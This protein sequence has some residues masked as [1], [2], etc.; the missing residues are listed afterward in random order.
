MVRIMAS[1]CFLDLGGLRVIYNAYF[2]L[3]AHTKQLVLVTFK[4]KTAGI[5]VG[6]WMDGRMDGRK[7]N[8]RWTDRCGS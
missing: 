6:F 1:P 2:S 4:D 7:R 5:G 3:L 8:D